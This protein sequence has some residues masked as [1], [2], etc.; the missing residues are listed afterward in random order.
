MF[1][2]MMG[3]RTTTGEAQRSKPLNVERHG[4][5]ANSHHRLYMN[6]PIRSARL[7]AICPKRHVYSPCRLLFNTN[8]NRSL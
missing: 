8:D 6:K 5:T 1:I 2:C 4:L 7:I 3:S